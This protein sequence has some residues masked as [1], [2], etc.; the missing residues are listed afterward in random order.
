[1][2]LS[3]S[4]FKQGLLY[5]LIWH[6]IQRLYRNDKPKKNYTFILSIPSLVENKL[7]LKIQ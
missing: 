7:F 4:I 1:M 6:Y 2:E 5:H 3:A